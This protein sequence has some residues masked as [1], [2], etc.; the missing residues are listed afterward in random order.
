VA[1]ASLPNEVPADDSSEAVTPVFHAF[2]PTPDAIVPGFCGQCSDDED[3][4]VDHKCCGPEKCRECVKADTC[5]DDP[6]LT[7]AVS[8]VW[9][10]AASDTA[11]NK[12][13]FGPYSD[14][15]ECSQFRN[16]E[17]LKMTWQVIGAREPQFPVD[18]FP[19][20]GLA[21]D[22]LG[23]SHSNET[24]LESSHAAIAICG[25]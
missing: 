17:A 1:G 16:N 13:L 11:G 20:A 12:Y 18:E 7:V 9:G 8:G 2:N 22:D 10:F 3:C 21:A 5:P 4:G 15:I 6:A 23:E 24:G 14:E 25:K 19:S